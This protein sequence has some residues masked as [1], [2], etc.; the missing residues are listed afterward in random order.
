MRNAV[1]HSGELGEFIERQAIYRDAEIAAMYDLPHFIDKSRGGWFPAIDAA[2][3]PTETQFKG[4]P[5]LYHSV[6]A[7]LFPLVPDLSHQARALR[8]ALA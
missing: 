1:P 4:K 6:Q 2:G 5:D 7:A 8:G 3:Q